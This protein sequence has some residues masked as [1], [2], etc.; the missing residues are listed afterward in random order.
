MALAALLLA[1]CGSEQKPAE[2]PP[3]K[4]TVF[5]DTVA[6]MDQ[7]RSV[8]GTVMQEKEDLD[9]ALQENEHPTAE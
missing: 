6:T 2:P 8:E 4:D 7:A 5:G 1:A 3:V 9:R